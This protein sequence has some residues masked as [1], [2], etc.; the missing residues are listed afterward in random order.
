MKKFVFVYHGFT[1]PTQEVM[2]AWT[3]WFAEI[4]DHI[5]DSGNPFGAGREVTPT[6]TRELPLGSDSATG[7]SIV[8]ADSIDD[9]EKLL[10]NCP[11]T[12]SVRINEAVSM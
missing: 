8:N 11:V 1:E 12:T 9:A 4:S 2:D 3:N 6:G 5:V 10:A 7:Y